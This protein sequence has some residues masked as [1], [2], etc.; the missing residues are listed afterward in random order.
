MYPK[1]IG[2]NNLKIK[3]ILYFLLC[4]QIKI[5]TNLIFLNKYEFKL[6][7]KNENYYF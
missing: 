3:K 1:L 4:L 2:F 7:K 6:M 5:T